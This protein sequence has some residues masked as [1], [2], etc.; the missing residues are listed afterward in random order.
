M[1]N[2]LVYVKNHI[3]KS[4]EPPIL[5]RKWS[6]DIELQ[7]CPPKHTGLWAMSTKQIEKVYIMANI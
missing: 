1:Q 7:R 5:C 3:V 4:L 2:L 6:A